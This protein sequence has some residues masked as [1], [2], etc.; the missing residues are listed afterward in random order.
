MVK[1]SVTET[2]RGTPGRFPSSVVAEKDLEAGA[3]PDVKPDKL[4]H[5]QGV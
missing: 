3:L 4:E 2:T 5:P 1:T